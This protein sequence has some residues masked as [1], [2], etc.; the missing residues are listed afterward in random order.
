MKR[1]RYSTIAQ[2][3]P[4]VYGVF[5]LFG[6][7]MVCKGSCS[8]FLPGLPYTL[9]I[10]RL[11]TLVSQF[12]SNFYLMLLLAVLILLEI[13]RVMFLGEKIVLL[14]EA[15]LLFLYSWSIEII[16]AYLVISYV[17][18]KVLQNFISEIRTLRNAP[19]SCTLGATLDV[20]AKKILASVMPTV[21]GI[22]IL[23]HVIYSYFLYVSVL[24]ML[25]YLVIVT[26]AVFVALNECKGNLLIHCVLAAIPP[27]GVVTLIHDI[28]VLKRIYA[29]ME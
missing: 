5:I 27:F 9:I 13:L 4:I 11:L 17:G 21:L 15:L 19:S 20:A 16:L 23:V 12:I 18:L 29:R 22:C 7:N 2:L 6:I 10:S 24:S 8:I 14:F 26:S 3:Y 25:A 28:I 1:K